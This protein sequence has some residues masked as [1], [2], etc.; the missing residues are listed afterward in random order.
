MNIGVDVRPLI[1]PGTGNANFLF[2]LLK[3]VLNSSPKHWKWKLYSHK[4]IHKEYEEI[5]RENTEL[6]IHS[7]SS[8]RSTIGPVWLHLYLPNILKKHKIDVFWSTLFLLPYDFKK[9]INIPC[10]LNIHDLNAWMFPKTMKYWENIYLKIFTKN[11]LKNADTILC[12]SYT[13][14]N[15]LLKHFQEDI[16][17]LQKKLEVVY[18]GIIKP[19]KTKKPLYFSIP[20]EYHFYLAVGTIEPRKNFETLIKSYLDAQKEF[21]YLPSLIIAGKPGWKMTP[22]LQKLCNNELKSNNIFFFSSPKLEELYWLYKN[23]S[24]FFYPSVYEGF[25]LQ[26]LEAAYFKK[27]QILSKI[28]IFEEIGKH[29]EG[30]FFIEDPMDTLLWKEKILFFSEKRNVVK[31]SKHIKNK[32]L[33]LFDYNSSAIK[34]IQ[35]LSKYET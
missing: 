33:S 26:I 19:P 16:T 18:P 1:Y 17:N 29:L 23:C 2:Y 27:I 13:T 7:C 12:L 25:G 6:H 31:Y 35:L 21:S 30:I 10:L 8:V 28:Q 20:N 5:I 3:E 11:S 24:V 22:L 14:Q 34:I 15:L 9:R 4:S 32:N